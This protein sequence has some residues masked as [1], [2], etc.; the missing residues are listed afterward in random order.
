MKTVGLT[1]LAALLVSHQAFAW[2]AVEGRYG[3]AAYRGPYS[4]GVRAPS[5]AAAVRGPAGNVAVR[6]PTTYGYGYH[7][8]TAYA[9]GYHPPTYGYPAGAAAAGAAVGV[10]A[11]VAALRGRTPRACG[12]CPV[13]SSRRSYYTRP[14]YEAA[15]KTKCV[16]STLNATI[17]LALTGC[18]FSDLAS[19]RALLPRLV[20]SRSRRHRKPC[21]Q[22]IASTEVN[23]AEHDHQRA[24]LLAVRSQRTD[25]LLRGRYAMRSMSILHFGAAIPET[26]RRREPVGV[27]ASPVLW[28][29]GQWGRVP[30]A[31]RQSAALIG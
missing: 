21:C 11:G 14:G 24:S 25:L 13:S 31:W 10:A 7:P 5:G 23:L 22:S 12:G 4:A 15:S 26:L 30:T 2:G 1:L 19:I 28:P 29:E 18:F 3:G 6:G 20:S 16:R 27:R 17:F 8:P 9:Y